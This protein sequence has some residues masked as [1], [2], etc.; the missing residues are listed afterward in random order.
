[1]ATFLPAETWEW[2]GSTWLRAGVNG[3]PLRRYDHAMAY[4]AKRKVTILFGGTA[5]A[6]GA[7]PGFPTDTWTWDGTA[8]TRVA[9]SGPS[10]RYR[11][12]MVYDSQREVVVLFGGE[13]ADDLH[14][15][16]TAVWEWNG[17][18]WLL[19]TS[20]GVEGRYLP[21]AVYDSSRR[22]IV[23]FGGAAD[24]VNHQFTIYDDTWVLR[25]R[26]TWVDFG[27]AGNETGGFATPFNTL[28]EAA[29][30]AP[31]GTIVNIKTGSSSEKLQLSK[32][33]TINAIGGP[34]IIG[35]N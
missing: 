3:P 35:A 21:A 24:D 7:N 31:S 19:Q 4:D 5:S 23:R 14:V 30:F 16:S 29:A 1:M 20:A 33:M 22:E 25:L 12:K 13:H 6:D 15:E 28:Q 9:T 8:W 34:A 26:E 27:Y 2:D 32:P 17:S 11:P 10:G 18:Q